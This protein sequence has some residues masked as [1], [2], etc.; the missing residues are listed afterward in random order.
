[1]K[2]KIENAIYFLVMWFCTSVIV[3]GIIGMIFRLLTKLKK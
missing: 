2:N 3:L 1:M